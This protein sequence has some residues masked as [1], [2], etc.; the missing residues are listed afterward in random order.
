[1]LCAGPACVPQQGLRAF[2]GKSWHPGKTCKRIP[3]PLFLPCCKLLPSLCRRHG[4]AFFFKYDPSDKIK[5]VPIMGASASHFISRLLVRMC[6]HIQL[7]PCCL[8][9]SQ[10]LTCP[11][12]CGGLGGPSSRR[13]I[14]F[15][16]TG[17][18]MT[19]TTPT[20]IVLSSPARTYRLPVRVRVR[21][22]RT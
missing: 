20:G 15:R 11:C 6:I 1:M 21:R 22:I 7:P 14:T 5:A 16:V 18:V 2:L 10:K 3:S 4:V 9:D 13:A 19:G 12:C 17:E 8:W